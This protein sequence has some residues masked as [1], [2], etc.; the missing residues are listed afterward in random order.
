MEGES[1]SC[2]VW[3]QFFCIE[4]MIDEDFRFNG[5]LRASNGPRSFDN[6]NCS[7]A[8][9]SSGFGVWTDTKKKR[10]RN[11]RWNVISSLKQFLA[12]DS[13]EIVEFDSESRKTRQFQLTASA[14]GVAK[15]YIV[16]PSFSIPSVFERTNRHILRTY[17]RYRQP[18]YCPVRRVIPVRV[19]SKPFSPDPF[20]LLGL[21]IPAP[22]RFLLLLRRV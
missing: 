13:S 8:P 5:A 4:W 16:Q 22:P 20:G 21:H 11:E 15:W 17:F 12:Y 14:L 2:W 9:I 18:P 6:N 19:F 3:S 10:I 7:C 1:R